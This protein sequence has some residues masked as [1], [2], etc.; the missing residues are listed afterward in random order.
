MTIQLDIVAFQPA[1]CSY[2]IADTVP[3]SCP[4]ASYLRWTMRRIGIDRLH[5]QRVELA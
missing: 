2:C 3:T 5:L 4:P 1:R